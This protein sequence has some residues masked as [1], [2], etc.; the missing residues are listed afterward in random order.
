[1][2]EVVYIVLFFSFCLISYVF[3]FLVYMI[4]GNCDLLIKLVKMKVIEKV[5][6]FRFVYIFG[7]NCFLYLNVIW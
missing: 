5:C 3:F 4:E 2:F 6:F 7:V 1:M